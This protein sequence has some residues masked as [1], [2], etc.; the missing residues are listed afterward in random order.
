MMP[1]KKKYN[2]EELVK[3]M[4]SVEK[5]CL[6]KK[7][8]DALPNISSSTIIR[9]F[10]SWRAALAFANLQEGKKTGR[11][12]LNKKILDKT[13]SFRKKTD[14][15][16]FFTKQDIYELHQ[17]HDPYWV[18]NNGVLPFY[19][20]LLLYIEKNGWIY[21]TCEE[22]SSDVVAKLKKKDGRVNS[23]DR[24]GS[25]FM[26]SRFRSFWL[27]SVRRLPNPT[28][29][30]Q[31]SKIMVPL[32][33]YRFGISNSKLY[34]YKFGDEEAISHE[35]FDISFKSVR[36]SLEVNRYV[37]SLFKP[38]LAKYVYQTFGFNGMR[39]WDPCGG[40]GGR[41]LGFAGTFENGSY[42]ANEPNTNTYEE[43]VSLGDELSN[44]ISIYPEPIEEATIPNDMDMVFTSPPY[45][46]KEHYCDSQKQSDVKY[47]TYQQWV[48]GF[49]TTLITKSY[50]AL[51]SGGKFILVVDAKNTN[52][53]IELSNQM[54]FILDDQIPITNTKTHLNKSP[55]CENCLAFIKPNK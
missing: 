38:L 29:C 6:S 33:K 23:S 43:L 34:R 36:K 55:N 24:I 53:C 35:L 19:E 31:D 8:I 17:A 13:F 9:E 48:D 2:R 44:D 52:P 11:N 37:V 15:H 21:P 28:I 25:Q 41:M 5:A 40:F 22:S 30:I 46:F 54:G 20:Y 27:A 39:V 26:K 16:I 18:L 10:G 3:I 49:L 47:S 7:D 42:I 45:G 1:R 4:R 32:L 51:K 14:S 50:M 12:P